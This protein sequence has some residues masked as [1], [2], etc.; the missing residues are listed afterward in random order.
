MSLISNLEFEIKWRLRELLR[1]EGPYILETAR[2]KALV[3][4]L[5]VLETARKQ[6]KKA[7]NETMQGYYLQ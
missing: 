4:N 2:G 1:E 6:A 3:K 7:N 5:D